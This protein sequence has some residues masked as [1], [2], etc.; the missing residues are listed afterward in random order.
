M[1]ERGQVLM[2]S[3]HRVAS[4]DGAGGAHEHFS[5]SGTLDLAPVIS[6]AHLYQQAETQTDFG[7]LCEGIEQIRGEPNLSALNVL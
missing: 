7:S 2:L 6:K 5:P 1:V 4:R 3:P